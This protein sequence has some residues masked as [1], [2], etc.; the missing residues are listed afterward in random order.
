MQENIQS[1]TPVT[2]FVRKYNEKG[3]SRFHMPG[4]KGKAVLGCEPY[5]ITEINGADVLFYADGILAES[6]EL[7]S[8][9]F[10]TG[11]TF[12][13][14]EGSSLCIKAMLCAVMQ[15]AAERG[16]CAGRGCIAAARNVHKSFV[17]ACALL[18][19]DM[20]SIVGSEGENYI[21]SICCEP[22]SADELRDFL[23][24][25]QESGDAVLAV[26]VTS[27]DYLGN[28]A[29]I[30]GISAVCDEY[31]IPLIADNAHGAYLAFLD[32]S[33]HP[34]HNGAAIC[35][36]SAHKTLPVLTGGAYIHI[37]K[38]WENRLSPYISRA[39]AVFGSTSPSYLILQSLDMCNRYLC[40]GYHGKLGRTI[41][42]IASVRKTLGSLGI[43][44]LQ[45]EPLKIVIDA[46]VGGYTGYET[47]DEMRAAG[48]ECEYADG[49]YIVLMASPENDERDFIRLE[50]WAQNSVLC[51]S[52]GK[53]RCGKM[54]TCGR[55]IPKRVMSIRNAVFAPSEMIPAEESLG[56]ICASQTVSCPPAVPI[57][58]SG[59]E[60]D[61]ETLYLFQKYGI[62]K[63]CVVKE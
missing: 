13:S 19:L 61:S 53:V 33:K 16:T 8:A 29:D 34:I 56:R 59:E 49:N 48:I 11:R 50:K 35:C 32:E 36:D 51:G 43:A 1:L 9:I 14:T 23:K 44:C 5:D 27:V 28:M 52:A 20:V 46:G 6:Q 12:F 24:Q 39:L 25:R 54:H 47:A 3:I 42:R 10:R 55:H 31:N 18:D 63:V 26:Y 22:V 4:H 40:E 2:D 15:E 7:A 30:S 21:E 37:S 45:G 41:E 62:N 38:E 57:I 17:D 58:I 60:I